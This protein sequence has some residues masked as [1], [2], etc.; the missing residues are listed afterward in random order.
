MAG[1]ERNVNRWLLL[2]GLWFGGMMYALLL[3]GS[4]AV[5]PFVHFD[6][7]VHVG[8]FFGQFWL[9]SKIFLQLRRPVPVRA[10]L[11]AAVLLAGFSELAQGVFTVDRQADWTDAAADVA[12]AAAALYFTA[13]VSSA[14]C[15]SSLDG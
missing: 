9:L 1:G 11:A 13:Q 8:L 2:S 5:P 6:K 3:P 12:G 14:R 4:G 10:L 7:I 15:R